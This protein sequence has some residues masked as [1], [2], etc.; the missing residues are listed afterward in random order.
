MRTLAKGE[1]GS[2]TVALERNSDDALM[3]TEYRYGR[4]N[5]TTQYNFPTLNG[6]LEFFGQRVKLLD[7]L[8]R[9]DERR[10]TFYIS[11]RGTVIG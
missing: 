8:D 7:A 11:E 3:V 2:G 1:F 9:V 6:A 10:N 4:T 5:S